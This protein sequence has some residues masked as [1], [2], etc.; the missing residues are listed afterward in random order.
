MEDIRP[1]TYAGQVYFIEIEP[2]LPLAE[3]PADRQFGQG[4]DMA[5]GESLGMNRQ[6]EPFAVNNMSRLCAHRR[7]ISFQSPA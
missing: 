6:T 3:A 2:G 5:S 1:H 7:L 4:V